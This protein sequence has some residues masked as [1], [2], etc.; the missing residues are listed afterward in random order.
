MNAVL[1]ELRGFSLVEILVIVAV[2]GVVSTVAIPI[3][4]GVP[5]AAKKEK[6][7]QDVLVANNAIDSYLAS[8]GDPEQLTSE[9]V[10]TALKS[11]V[12][13]GMPA[14]MMGPQGP[15]IDLAV[16]TNATDFAWSAL[17]TTDPR[18]RFYVAQS[19][20]GVVFGKGPSMAIGGVAERPD[21]ARPSWLWTYG[22]AT[23]PPQQDVFTPLAVDTGV[24]PTNT[25]VAGVTLGPPLV[26]PGGTNG[27]LWNFPIPVLMTNTNPPG[28]SRIYFKVGSGNYSLFE[29][30]T[31]LSISPDTTLIAVCV[32]LDPSRYYNSTAASNFYGVTP[33][34]LAVKLTVPGSVTYA[35]AGGLLQGVNQ[36]Q[37]VSATITLEDA[38]LNDNLLVQE[39]GNDRFIPPAYLKNAN[40]FVRYTTDGSDPRTNGITGPAFDGFFSPVSVPLGLAVWGTNSAITVRAAAISSQP[41]FFT[42]SG[43][44]SG[45]ASVAPTSLPLTIVPANPIG[46]PFQVQLNHAAPVPVG[47]RKF[48]RTDGGA[49]LSAVSGGFAQAAAIAYSATVPST[50]LPNTA[51]TLTAQATGPAGSEQ[52]FSSPLAARNYTTITVLNPNFV[53]ANISGGDINGSFRGSIFVSAPADLGIFNAGGQ[54]VGGNLYVPGLPAI[55]TPGSGNSSKTVVARGAAFVDSAGLIPR[56]LIA[57]KEFSADG[58]LAD[59]QLDLRQ[60]VDLSGSGLP[61]NYTVKLTKSTFIEGKIFRNVDVPPPPPV[62][63]LP[64]GL[65]RVTGS[66][67]GVPATTLEPGIYSNNITMNST[68]STIRLGLAGSSAPARYI[69]AGHT[70]SKGT[71]EILGPVEVYFTSGWTNTGVVF[72]STNTQ[73]QLRLNVLG[74]NVD[75]KSGGALYGSL[76]ATNEVAVGNGGILFG[77]IFAQSLDVAPGGTVNVEPAAQP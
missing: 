60:I 38:A 19:A 52:W 6:L 15:F 36:L 21:E 26:S 70:F 7:E 69:F 32:S 46:L 20:A 10:L 1:S 48:Y 31:A 40:F 68:G 63:A 28:S 27:T 65:T 42:T 61:T 72:G 34:Q 74:G 2:I 54:I 9:N 11:R 25:A 13:G 37:P 49:P 18:P 17:F 45:K 57:G 5:D 75:L 12:Y 73:S 47:L 77:N 33:L 64:T 56:T 50:V 62:P 71:V 16:T 4:T 3:I 39:G 29:D 43:V 67:S 22:A 23:P 44:S 41:A 58:Q 8:G 55:E 35:Q 59:P 53:G 14:E 51:Y 30:G 66:F 24:S 76:W